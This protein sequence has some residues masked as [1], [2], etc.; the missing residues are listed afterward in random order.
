M[1]IG[2]RS[3]GLCGEARVRDFAHDAEA[4]INPRDRKV[5]DPITS[6]PVAGVIAFA[7]EQRRS[8]RQ[9]TRSLLVHCESALGGAETLASRAERQRGTTAFR[10]RVASRRSRIRIWPMP[11]MSSKT[12]QRGSG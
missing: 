1:L 6:N 11:A 4:G 10:G 12:Q 3:I 8:E 5:A 9:Q 2:D 7:Q